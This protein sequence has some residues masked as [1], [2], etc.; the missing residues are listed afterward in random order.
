MDLDN[1]DNDEDPTTGADDFWDFGDG[2]QYPALK[3]DFDHDGVATA[4]EFGDQGRTAAPGTT[5]A[6]PSPVTGHHCGGIATVAKDGLVFKMMSADCMSGP[7]AIR[8]GGYYTFTLEEESEVAIT[9]PDVSA[10]YLY[11]HLRAGTETNGDIAVTGPPI[12]ETLAAGTYTVEV[13]GRRF[14][15]FTLIFTGVE[16]ESDS[17][18]AP[19]TGEISTVGTITDLMLTVDQ[20]STMDVS[21]YFSGGGDMLT[22]TVGSSDP[23]IATAAVSGS[24]VTVTGVAAGSATITVTAAD[25]AGSGTSATQTF[26]VMVTAEFMAPVIMTTN[27][28]GGG[29]VIV[30]WG[31]V[32]GAAGYLL[33]ANNLSDP[34]GETRTAAASRDAVSGQIEGLTVGDEYL[35]FVGVFNDQLEY[36]LS[37]HVRVTAE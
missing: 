8:H 1:G 18:G 5:I 9:A 22:Y 32:V 24:M 20:V 17:I 28:V 35:I 34:S 23:M 10:G 13:V 16:T 6:E 27:P 4:G 19:A 14:T 29:I 33:I 12:R 37:E 30:S 31:P 26:D 3:A 21:M 25:M 2:A 15:P 11:L 36:E 7:W